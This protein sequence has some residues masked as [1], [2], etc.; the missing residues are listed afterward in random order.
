MQ[1][2]LGLGTLADVADHGQEEFLAFVV[3]ARDLHFRREHAAILAA[4]VGAQ[5]LGLTGAQAGQE[6]APF[7][8]AEVDVGGEHAVELLA[9]VAEAGAGLVVDSD[10]AQRAVDDHDAVSGLIEQLAETLL[11]LAQP[12]FGLVPRGDLVEV[13]RDAVRVWIHA[14][15]EPDLAR[16]PE[17]LE[18]IRLAAR[19]RQLV[20]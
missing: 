3:E 18:G 11:A 9:A 4:L 2:A 13:D 19:H 7:R 5:Q 6:R 14:H 16:H 15:L 1:A 8:E 20:A 17:G 10:D 12:V